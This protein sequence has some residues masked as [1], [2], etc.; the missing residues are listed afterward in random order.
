MQT[1][2]EE[3]K[4]RILDAGKKRFRADGFDK[5]SMKDIA[6]DAGISTGNIYRYFLTKSHLLDEILSDLE[7]E[8]KDFLNA[9]PEDYESVKG[10]TLFKLISDK[11]VELYENKEAEVKILFNCREQKQ[12]VIFREKMLGL[13]SKKI[14]AIGRSMDERFGDEILSAAIARSLF[15]GLAYIVCTNDGSIS[16]LKKKMYIYTE[17]MVGDLDKRVLNIAKRVK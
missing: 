9:I 12:F 3:V 5:A 16:E 4:K 7:V 8:L 17:L 14:E 10:N 15:E 6:N 1:L 2:K 13:L 11:I